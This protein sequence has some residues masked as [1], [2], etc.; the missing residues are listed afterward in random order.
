MS[1]SKKL[2]FILSGSI[3]AYKACEALSR[4]VQ[5]GCT[6][7]VVAT[8]AALRYVGAATLEGLTGQPVLSDLWESGRALDHIQLTRWA[9]AVVVCPATANTINRLAAGLADDLVGAL[10][11]ARDPAKPWLIA[12]AMNPAMWAHPA[13]EAAVARLREW[14]VRFLAVGRGRTACGET[15]EGR[16]AEA[17]EVALAVDA[18]LARPPRKLR[19]LITSGGTAEAVDGV[20]ILTNTSTGRTGARLAEHF[21]RAGH[22]VTL[23]RAMHAVPAPA[24]VTER[25]YFSFGDLDGALTELLGG[26]DFEAV[27]HAAAVSDFHV[28]G[29]MVEG[30]ARPAGAKL[31]SQRPASILLRP[32]PKLVAGL[33]AR[34]RNQAVQV[35]A[36]KLTRGATASEI[37]AAVGRLFAES[38][39]DYVVHNDL[40]AQGAQ[41]DDFPATVHLRDGG[42]V[43]CGS[44]TILA[45][46]L[47]RSLLPFPQSPTIP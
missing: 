41:P 27:I 9:D 42:V 39:A 43:R 38:P 20:R 40:A 44:R 15:G 29:V 16:L 19:V 17:A 23:L 35:V 2:L 24:G 22:E 4:L 31:D 10:F 6:V 30:V 33:R 46:C 37:Q 11:L 47:E 26:N 3:A 13:T 45:E 28:A 7:R 1:A 36:F 8:P 32:N 18:L 5:A 34:S 12:P 25:I 21:A 14:D